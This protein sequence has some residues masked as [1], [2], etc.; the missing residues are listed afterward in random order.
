[1]KAQ[2]GVGEQWRG[3]IAEIARSAGFSEAPPAIEGLP[4]DGSERRFFRLRQG[5]RHAVLLISP[6][7]KHDG[8]D[9]NDSYFLIGKH[10]FERGVPVPRFFWTDVARGI[11]LLEDLGDHH[12]QTLAR[13]W[14]GN[15][16]ALY[17]RVV[18]LLVDL[19]RRA[20]DGFNADYCFDCAVYDSAFVYHRELEY[21][22]ERFLNGCLGLE[23]GPDDL[24]HD[25]ERL[26]EA[27]GDASRSHVIHRDFQSRN[28]MVRAQALRLIDFQGMR[29][30]PPA[31]DLA[32]VLI[33]PY[34]A[35]PHGLERRLVVLY[36]TKAGREL[37]CSF[38]HFVE[39]YRAVRLCR[40]FQILGAYGYLGVVKGKRQF[41]RYIPLAWQQL[42]FWVN[43]AV[44]GRYPGVQKL[45]KRIHQA[46]PL[47]LGGNGRGKVLRDK[48]PIKSYKPLSPDGELD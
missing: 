9:E 46:H 7:Q 25:F 21:F 48:P 17:G 36:W 35:I 23:I 6:R 22:R 4:G 5:D 37:A 18:Q 41:L 16:F 15:L 8:I 10:L 31:Y 14:R 30:G 20:A 45:V 3:V 33:D 19:H 12:L 1:M 43:G 13:R 24:R 32:S 28:I 2:G 34:V 39:S 47:V 40:N 26:A 29:F 27:A 44:A 38:R 11:F 42:Y